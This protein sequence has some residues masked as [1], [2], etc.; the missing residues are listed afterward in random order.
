LKNWK[1][2]LSVP[3]DS[4]LKP[5]TLAEIY[6]CDRLLVEHHRGILGYGTQCIRIAATYGELVV[7][8]EDLRLCCMSRS[9][10]VIRGRLKSVTMEER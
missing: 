9:Q 10:L 3:S 7:E 8:G 6:G 5:R 2:R 4:S 1:E